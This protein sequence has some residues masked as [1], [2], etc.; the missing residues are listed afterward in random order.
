MVH[1]YRNDAIICEKA[2]G[3]LKALENEF[4]TK[5]VDETSSAE[6]RVYCEHILREAKSGVLAPVGVTMARFPETPYIDSVSVFMRLVG[7]SARGNDPD[8]PPTAS[9]DEDID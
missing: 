5:A 1:K 9:S 8:V 7:N 2:I 3:S 6:F 4:E